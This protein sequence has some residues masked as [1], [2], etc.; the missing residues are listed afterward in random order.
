MDL[1]HFIYYC[2]VT[3]ALGETVMTGLISANLFFGDSANRLPVRSLWLF[4]MTQIAEACFSIFVLLSAKPT[5]PA[6]FLLFI[7][8]S[9][10]LRFWTQVTVYDFHQT[11]KLW[12]PRNA[13][14]NPS[15]P[16]KE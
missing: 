12:R 15:I 13:A 11:A 16:G 7:N 6:Y 4:R 1:S 2:L 9:I 10:W 3:G 14:I 8:T 5:W